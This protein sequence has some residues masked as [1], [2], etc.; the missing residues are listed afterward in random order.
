MAISDEVANLTSSVNQLTDAVNVKKATLDQ[1]VVD[2]ATEANRA[3]TEADRS[4]NEANRSRDEANRADAE[5]NR[6]RDEADTAFQHANTALNYRDQAVAVVT[7]D[8][9]SIPAASGKVPVAGTDAKI[10]YDYLPMAETNAKFAKGVI[11]NL[12]DNLADH[13]SA[14]SQ[15]TS[16]ENLDTEV[17]DIRSHFDAVTTDIQEQIDNLEPGVPAS[18]Q[19]TVEQDLLIDAFE[20]SYT[21]EILRGMGGSGWYNNR[22]YNVDSGADALHRPFTVTSTVHFQHNHPN[23]YRMVGLGEQTAIVNGYYVRTGHNDPRLVDQD[24]AEL[25]APPIPADVLAKPT[26]VTINGSSVT[27]DTAGDTQARYMRNIYKDNMED[28][29]LDLLYMEVWIEKLP[30]TGSLNNTILSFRHEQNSNTLRRLHSIAEKMN[31]SGAKDLSE[32]GSFRCGIISFVDDNGAPEYGYVNYRLRAKSVGK[33]ATRVPKSSYTDGDITPQLSWTVVGAAFGG[34]HGHA[35]DVMLTPSEANSILSGTPFF[36]ETSYN[37][38]EA[39]PSEQEHSHL[40][41][42]TATASGDITGISVGAKAIGAPANIFLAS[43]PNYT[44]TVTSYRRADGST[45]GPVIW[46]TSAE[47]HKHEMEVKVIQDRFP[48]DMYKAVNHIIDDDNRFKLVKDQEA[49]RR[50]K[51]MRG[52]SNP[53]WKDLA[54]S[55]Y[56]RWQL[57]SNDMNVICEGVWGLDGEGAFLP[58][59]INTGFDRDYVTYEVAGTA[60]LNM[61]RYNR[62]FKIGTNDAAGRT[63][64][65]RGFSDPTLYVAKTTDPTVVEGYSYMI[66]LELILRSPTEIWN[67]WDL[68]LIEGYP[69]RGNTSSGNG[70]QASPWN[71]AYTQLWYN[72]LP[73][74]FFSTGVSDPADTVTGG[75]WIEANDGNAYPADNSGIYISRNNAADFRDPDGNPYSSV[76]RFRYAIGPVWHDFT[77]GNVQLNNFK[78][79]MKELLKGIASGTVS[80]SDIDDVI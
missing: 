12:N 75:R 45:A 8:Q 29:R 77:Y 64:A 41:E 72:L 21:A 52:F 67:P 13:F 63:V 14:L 69:G 58:E 7:S 47:P 43:D 35:L 15:D 71:A 25:D 76:M 22:N 50:L 3:D 27:I 23:Y 6:S 53:T 30:A 51:D 36:I 74:N 28:T 2:A 20:S 39:S 11:E 44:P 42:L 34:T 57:E 24:G 73:P 60:R 38:A 46:D 26:G 55:G 66:P 19:G 40:W 5:A 37:K 65:R 31:F 59:E 62:L 48:F 16:I 70:S 56:A 68:K 32:N 1:K 61:A 17:E 54:E 9:G 4:R 79:T 10:D 33:M 18:F 49:L 78:N 80:A